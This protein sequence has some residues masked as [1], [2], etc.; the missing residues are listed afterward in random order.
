[1]LRTRLAAAFVI[2]ALAGTAAAQAPHVAPGGALDH[3]TLHDADADH[4]A[5]CQPGPLVGRCRAVSGDPSDPL[6]GAVFTQ[7]PFGIGQTLYRSRTLRYNDFTLDAAPDGHE[8]VVPASVAVDVRLRGFLV[9]LL[10]GRAGVAVELRV[11]D[12]TGGVANAPL[13]GTTTIY[14]EEVAGSL[15]TE[16]SASAE[17]LVPLPDGNIGIGFGLGVTAARKWVDERRRDGVDLLLQRGHRYRIQL[18]LVASTDVGVGGGLAAASFV[19]V[20]V[21]SVLASMPDLTNPATWASLVESLVNVPELD[22]SA[23]NG[24]LVFDIPGLHDLV[25][26]TGFDRAFN[27]F[28]GATFDPDDCSDCPAPLDF[29]GPVPAIT[30]PSQG[31]GIHIPETT[32]DLDLPPATLPFGNLIGNFQDFFDDIGL[33]PI[34]EQSGHRVS[35]DIAGIA[36]WITD[37]APRPMILSG[38]TGLQVLDLS[39]TVQDDL[40]QQARDHQ[41]ALQADLAARTAAILARDDAN[42][43]AVLADAAA[44]RAAV[45]ATVT[46]EA[47]DIRANDDANRDE[48]LDAIAALRAGQLRRD[49]EDNL[50]ARTCEPWMYTPALLDPS[51]PVELGGHF[52]ETVAGVRAVLD[53]ARQLGTIPARELARSEEDLQE[54]EGIVAARPPITEADAQDICQ[55]LI[56]AYARGTVKPH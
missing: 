40:F 9:A 20:D 31:I 8:T 7:N 25:G 15:S 29:N 28:A 16:V 12:I 37:R 39:V 23:A 54:A 4:Q 2:A 47:A 32:F 3:S 10:E 34:V 5:T 55:L 17:I 18:E 43:A 30:L 56:Q 1:M 44:N 6:Q 42:T 21:D 27:T 36:E 35:L 24:D 51:S 13:V 41:A 46:S 33:P 53:A 26:F 52:E 50:G 38:Q 11:L 49:V 48:L 45:L 14:E 19:S 22:L